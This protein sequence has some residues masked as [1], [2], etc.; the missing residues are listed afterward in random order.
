MDWRWRSE[1]KSEGFVFFSCLLFSPFENGQKRA[2]SE[3]DWK[4]RALSLSRSVSIT[5]RM[6]VLSSR[7]RHVFQPVVP[8]HNIHSCV[9]F[10]LLVLL[11]ILVIIKIRLYQITQ[12]A[13]GL[14]K[15]K[16][17]FHFHWRHTI[18]ARYVILYTWPILFFTVCVFFSSFFFL[19]F[20]KSNVLPL[21][22]LQLQ[23]VLFFLGGGGRSIYVLL[24]RTSSSS[25]SSF[26]GG[27]LFSK[28]S[29]VVVKKDN[30]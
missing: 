20:F 5:R 29:R 26:F 2:G 12:K 25:N 4:R 16:I 24:L 14:L 13:Q 21:M 7:R 10:R 8:E 1:G 3:I 22:C 11:P 30:V 19:Y 6:N 15:A 28:K 23:C 9:F 27:F 17:H 18:Y